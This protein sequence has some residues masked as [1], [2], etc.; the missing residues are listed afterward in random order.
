MHTESNPF[1]PLRNPP[2]VQSLTC[3]HIPA[4]TAQTPASAW[5][6]VA[7]SYRLVLEKVRLFP[8]Y[9]RIISRFLP[10]ARVWFNCH[11]RAGSGGD[12]RRHFPRVCVCGLQM[13]SFRRAQ[14]TLR[15]RFGKSLVFALERGQRSFASNIHRRAFIRRLQRCI[16]LARFKLSKYS[17]TFN[18]F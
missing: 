3:T 6:F 2:T 8:S 10:L 7:Y 13:E 4:F 16:I 17:L 1:V 18:R 5:S 12:S 9:S 15:S 14:M 11:T